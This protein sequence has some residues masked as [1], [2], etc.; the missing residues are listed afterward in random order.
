GVGRE[1]KARGAAVAAASE[2]SMAKLRLVHRDTLSCETILRR[3]PNGE[4]FIVSQCGDVSEPAPLNRVYIFHSKDNGQ[5]WSKGQ[6][7]YPEDG[8]AVYATEV[9]VLGGE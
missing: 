8:R 6:S 7:V 1:K 2:E 5:T 9:T 4:L 3:A